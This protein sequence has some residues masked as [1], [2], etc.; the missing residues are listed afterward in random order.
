MARESMPGYLRFGGT[1]NDEL[2]Y[3]FGNYNCT[4]NCLNATMFH[5]LTQL[6]N[7]SGA[8]LVFALNIKHSR[9][10]VSDEFPEGLWD[11]QNARDLLLHGLA[12]NYTFYGFELGEKYNMVER[13]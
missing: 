9:V 3:A 1:G 2:N 4:E 12:R 13:N 5:D 6:A 10:N 7:V 8:Q 11:P